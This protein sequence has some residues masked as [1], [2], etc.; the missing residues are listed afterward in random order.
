MSE[1]LLFAIGDK[2]R[3]VRRY[4][5]IGQSELCEK[6]GIS[7]QH[8]SNIERGKQPAS[9]ILLAEIADALGCDLIVNLKLKE[10]VT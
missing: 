9:I 3:T 8:L 10:L 7:R 6:L 4:R 2:F 1:T 5:N